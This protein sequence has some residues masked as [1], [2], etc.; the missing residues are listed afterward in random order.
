MWKWITDI[1]NYIKKIIKPTPT[2]PG[3][4]PVDPSLLRGYGVVNN[5][6]KLTSFNT[7]ITTLKTNN[8]NCTYIEFF[9]M[10]EDGWIDKEN[11]IKSQFTALVTEARRQGITV[12]VNIMNWGNTTYITRPD[13]WFQ[14]W[15]DYIKT[16]GPEKLVIQTASEWRDEKG[17]RWCQ[18]TEDTLTGFTLSWNKGSRPSTATARYAYIDYHSA[19][20]SDLGGTDKRTICDTDSGILAEMQNGGIKGPS[21]IPSKVTQFATGAIG[22]GKNVLLYGY[23]HAVVDV[24][25]IKALGRVGNPT[26]TPD[27]TPGPTPT[28]GGFTFGQWNWVG[29]LPCHKDATIAPAAEFTTATVRGHN[30]NLTYGP[31]AKTTVWWPPYDAFCYGPHAT[32]YKAADGNWYAGRV[33]WFPKDCR[34]SIQIG[35]LWKSDTPFAAHP[36]VVG[37]EAYFFVYSSDGR[38]RSKEI[39]MIWSLTLKQKIVKMYR[40]LLRR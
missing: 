16:F 6:I 14:G 26:P 11:I 31:N 37:N 32:A 8:C 39:Q 22:Q 34:P 29:D 36:P 23:N 10:Y 35:N 38:N 4:T 9:G 20:M 7:L 19:S 1:I 33:D 21:F 27:P 24:D 40:K 18:M 28:P 13:S 30:V 2:P 25:A 17:A 15:L 12:F 5:W 3:P